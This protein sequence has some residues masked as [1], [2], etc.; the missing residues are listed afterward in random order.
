VNALWFLSAIVLG[1]CI[2]AVGLS[3]WFVRSMN[4]PE[5][6]RKFLS[7]TYK[8]VHAHWLQVSKDDAT[9][10]CPCCGWSPKEHA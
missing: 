9:Q 10:V 5:N 1:M 6:A 3:L 2:G 8:S 7:D 4:K